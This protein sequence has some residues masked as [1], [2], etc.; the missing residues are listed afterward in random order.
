M[1]ERLYLIDDNNDVRIMEKRPYLDE[2]A[3]QQLLA[4]IPDLL[5]G[6]EIDENAPRRWALVAREMAVPD[7]MAG[8]STMS[9]DHLFLDQDGIPTLVE[10]KRIS[11]TR[12]RREVV[13]QLLDYAANAVA[14][15]PL[16]TLRTRFEATCLASNQEPDAVLGKLLQEAELDEERSEEF[17]QRVKTNL[18]AGRLRL[19][20]AADEIPPQLQRIV[21]FLNEQ[22]A[23]AEVLAVEL[24]Q[25]VGEGWR[26]IVPRIVGQTAEAGR[27]KG[28]GTGGERYQWDETSFFAALAENAP[29]QAVATARQIL[30]WVR[31][32]TSRI[33]WG[34]GKVEGSFVPIY[35]DGAREH[36]LFVIRTRGSVELYVHVYASKPPFND[37]ALLDELLQHINAIPGITMPADAF[38]RQN[39]VPL[40]VLAPAP[41]LAQFFETYEWY[42]EQIRLAADR[43]RAGR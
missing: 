14:Y 41:V 2:D 18:K 34:T 11:D 37:P 3:L 19:I 7:A 5:A 38:T 26:T 31:P 9:L 15:W 33:Y 25:F 21:E 20:F 29:P 1:A 8:G 35:Y 27:T 10:V 24:P 39:H 22:M 42:L 43:D 32:R 28:A 16:E 4:R 36:R 12:I 23:L 13:G 30:E 40:E 17:W 6:A